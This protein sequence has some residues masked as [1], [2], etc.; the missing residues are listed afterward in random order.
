MKKTLLAT[1]TLIVG[2]VLSYAQGT[3]S[4]NNSSS[5]FFIRTNGASAGLGT[6]NAGTGAKSYY[7]T[8]LDN[9][10]YPGSG[11]PSTDFLNNG[12][13]LANWTW[14][15]VMGTNNSLTK[16]AISGV[17]SATANNW[18]APTGAAYSSG[19]TDYYVVLGW[20]ANEG[21]DW[22]TISNS[23][24]T[25][26]WAVGAGGWFG[27]STVAFN[28]AGGGPSALPAVNVFGDSTGLSGGGLSGGFDL[29]PIPEPASFAI[30]GMGSAAML[31]F[32]RRK[33]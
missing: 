30:I 3:I 4:L 25:G 27:F 11:A 23:I 28:E 13:N 24:V 16:G 2:T 33:Q 9:A 22:L 15:G 1:L 31:I 32:R 18:G 12:A 17:A 26:Q 29:L 20:S 10:N 8:V 19:P 21:S 14:T 6:G 7:Y 5:T